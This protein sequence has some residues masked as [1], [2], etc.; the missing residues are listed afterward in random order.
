M[1]LV[2]DDLKED[3]LRWQEKIGE[4]IYTGPKTIGILDVLRAHYLIVDFFY[5][6]YEEGVGGVGPKNLNLL[7]STLSRQTSSYGAQSKWNND[8]EICATLFWGLVKNHAFHDAN[9]RTA[10]LSLFYH[11]IKIKRFPIAR[12]KEYERLAIRTASNELDKYP[13]YQIFK[14]EEDAE[15][16]F[17]AHFL[18]ETTRNLNKEEFIITYRQLDTIL[19]RYS[20]R[21]SNP[22]RN[23]IDIVAF[24]EVKVGLFRKET[25]ITERRIGSIRFPGWTRQVSV[26]S[27]K[28]VRRMTKLTVDKG[29]DSESFFHGADSLPSL[30]SQFQPLL[31]SLANK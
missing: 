25:K 21:L 17:I 13:R 30:I 22:D 12:Q 9:K 10:M 28:Q 26:S 27:I 5:N 15:V 23:M 7:H 19:R 8:L 18:K 3:F 6:E 4:D 1:D 29:Y 2:S 16:K 14:S 11:L 31:I 24:Q 20:F